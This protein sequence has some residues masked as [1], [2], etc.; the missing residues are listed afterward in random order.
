MTLIKLN[1][2]SQNTKPFNSLTRRKLRSKT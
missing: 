1:T 2:N